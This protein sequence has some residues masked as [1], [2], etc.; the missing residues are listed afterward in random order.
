MLAL[1]GC[2]GPHIVTGAAPDTPAATFACVTTA[3]HDLGFTV[4][5]SNPKTG[6]VE[7]EKRDAGSPGGAEY[8][9]LDI[10]IYTNR[11][12]ETQFMIQASRT[13]GGGTSGT[14]S[15]GLPTLDSDVKA[16]DTVAKRCGKP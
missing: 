16:S 13:H 10:S 4:L 15:S 1:A 6:Y 14:G 3:L 2:F 8:T 11:D 12:G 5:S 9:N 7:G